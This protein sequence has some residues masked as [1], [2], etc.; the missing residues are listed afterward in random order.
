[1][2][3]PNPKKLSVVFLSWL[4]NF[5][6]FEDPGFKID[7]LKFTNVSRTSEKARFS[8]FI[9]EKPTKYFLAS[10]KRHYIRIYCLSAMPEQ[11]KGFS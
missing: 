3:T 10:T 7:A 4:V 6:S 11:T 1:M 5:K 2:L 9:N 8:N